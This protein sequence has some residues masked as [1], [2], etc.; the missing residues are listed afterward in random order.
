MVLCCAVWLN[1]HNPE[2]VKMRCA[3]SLSLARSLARN[4]DR[5]EWFQG[6]KGQMF[7][8]LVSAVAA[9]SKEQG[10]APGLEK[11]QTRMSFVLRCRC[12]YGPFEKT[13]QQAFRLLYERLSPV[14]RAWRPTMH[15]FPLH[16]HRPWPR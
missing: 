13:V 9:P 6:F 10:W 4:E 16:A 8:I 15:Y 2:L 1:V 5:N 7:R 3:R 11:V 14:V 12:F